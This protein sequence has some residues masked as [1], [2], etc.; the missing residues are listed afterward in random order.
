MFVLSVY[1][2]GNG[3]SLGPALQVDPL[4]EKEAVHPDSESGGSSQI[5]TAEAEADLT[6]FWYFTKTH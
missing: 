2:L 5:A 4:R 1:S 6:V 3:A